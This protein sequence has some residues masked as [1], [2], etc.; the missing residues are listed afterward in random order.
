MEAPRY[1]AVHADIAVDDD[2]VNDIVANY[3]L[4]LSNDCI[5]QHRSVSPSSVGK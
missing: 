5:Y 1:A 4:V 3:C 2:K